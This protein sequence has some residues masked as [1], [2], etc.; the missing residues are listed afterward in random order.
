VKAIAVASGSNNS[1]VAS[2]SN[3]SAVATV[4]YTIHPGVITPTFSPVAG[5]YATS[6][7]VTISDISTKTIYYTTDGSVPTTS[8]TPYSGPVTVASNKTIKAIAVLSGFT[9]SPVATAAYAIGM[10]PTPSFS[11]PA[12]TYA[13]SKVTISDASSSA[14]IYYTT[15]GTKPTTSSTK[16]TAP[17][18][19]N[20]SGTFTVKAIAVAS[21]SNNSAVASG[22]N[23]SAVATVVYTIHPGVITPT[24]SPVA[25]TYATSQSVTIS[26]ISTKT[27]YYTTDGSVPTTSSTPYSGPVT[28]AS[29][30]TIK[31]IAVLSGFTN[32]PVATAA[33]AINSVL[34]TPTFSVAAG[35]YTSAQ[36]VTIRD[37]TATATIYFTTSGMTPTTSSAIYTR[38]ITVSST[39]TVQALAVATGDTNS[40]VAKATYTITSAPQVDLSWEAPTSSSVSIVGFDIYR[41]TGSSSTYQLLNSSLDAQTTYMDSA[42]QSGTAYTYYVESVDSSGMQSAP[43]SPVSVTIP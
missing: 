24:F 2:G 38:P 34:P 10:L 16:Y 4:V 7:S 3:N 25:G 40:A 19:F 43:S 30:K 37:T 18:V 33:Y 31:A 41:A 27:I 28:V 5:T 29:N 14:T 12:G 13:N 17:I 22:S 21:G 6:Q 26:D 15:N 23:N 39:E 20:D 11:L 8:S 36:T 32:S 42:V 35:T 9:N 1:A